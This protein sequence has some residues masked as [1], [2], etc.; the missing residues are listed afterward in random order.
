MQRQFTKGLLELM[1][2]I[3]AVA[4]SMA[5]APQ[6]VRADGSRTVVLDTMSL[7]RLHHTLRPPM[8]QFA[9]GPKPV[10]LGQRWLNKETAPP[11]ADWKSPEFDDGA[12]LR[13]TALRTCRTPYLS[14][15]CMRGRFTVTDPVK[16]KELSVSVGYHG[17]AIVYVNGREI[18]RGHL[19]PG[20]LDAT[21]LAEE[22]PKEAY[23]NDDGS[24][25]GPAGGFYGLR[26]M[27]IN[28]NEEYRR[29][30][31]LHARTLA[32]LRVPRKL[33]RK[34]LNVVAV[35]II[36][37]AY[38]QVRDQQKEANLKGLGN[39]YQLLWNNCQINRVQLTAAGPDGLVPSAGRP[40]GLQIWN[41][42]SMLSDFDMDFGNPAEPLRPVTMV[43]A[44]NGTYS[45]KVVVGS[46][47]AIR[48]LKASVSELKGE[49]G[50]TIPASQMR[51]RYA[52]P[53]G[54]QRLTNGNYQ[55]EPNPYPARPRL[56]SCLVESPLE[57]FPVVQPNRPRS[58]AVVPV[59]VTVK[60][61]RD[62]RPG[63]YKGKLTVKAEGAKPLVA[64]LEMKVIGWTVPDPQNWR[65]WVE[66]I[67]SPDTLA[68]EYGAKL[69]S[70]E[71]FKLIAKSMR[72]LNEAGSRV[73]YV[74]LIAHTNLGNAESMVRWAAKDRGRWDYDFSVMDRYLDTALEHMGK[75]KLVVF[76]VW[77]VYLL[78]KGNSKGRQPRN[79]EK[80][81]VKLGMGPM[82]TILDTGTNE[83]ENIRLPLYTDP[84]SKG[85]WKS[86]FEA[87]RERMRKRGLEDTM[88][89]GMLTD[90]WASKQEMAFFKEIT[91]DL[92][93]VNHSH[94]G[95]AVGDKSKRMHGVGRIGY[96][97]TVWATKF[98]HGV[99]IHGKTWPERSMYGWKQPTLV[100]QFSRG[101]N[102]DG[103]TPTYWRHYGE[104]NITGGQR[105]MGRIGAD[106]WPVFKGRR[107]RKSGRVW[108]RFPKSHWNNLNITSS[109]LAPGPDG[110]VATDRFE[111]FREGIQ[112]CEARIAIERA[113]TDDALRK[114]LGPDLVKRC[115]EMFDE[116][117]PL[118]FK[119]LRSLH[120]SGPGWSYGT[121]G[122]GVSG[123]NWFVGSAWE[124]RTEKLYSLAG[125]VEKRLGKDARKPSGP[126]PGA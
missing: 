17:G 88:M 47:K 12:W 68:V 70:D 97:A 65:T 81:G 105:G 96:Q 9:D 120:L 107:G 14:R 99:K 55:R 43:G 106:F 59:W 90:V 18:G 102:Q 104:K 42:N 111:A 83:T 91:S 23:V 16:V 93:W 32:D 71:H 37:A 82:V 116:R 36:R 121:R 89:L 87:I 74:P 80:L 67:Q 6:K 110:P 35:E 76:N 114:K 39:A 75:P 122:G 44:R 27:K 98:S 33:L 118:M 56:L 125:E 58:G 1:V 25:V 7:W 92:P 66:L 119:S 34:G 20:A 5:G 2:L 113:L 46:D 103:S 62:A 49:A 48:G 19:P 21:T 13:G 4:V 117:H 79:L 8:V 45:G 100:A 28:R 26:G 11:A 40:A 63:L 115:E 53:W 84:A 24:W 123:P 86:L 109:V 112:E 101:T 73:L 54:E 108:L 94:N 78:P 72:H 31:G 15:L 22:Y 29:R 3:C 38:H 60:V 69:W 61:P 95:F 41:S 57:T 77:D 126:L 30:V 124:Q 85:P 51:I 50:G 10:L 52:L 64:A